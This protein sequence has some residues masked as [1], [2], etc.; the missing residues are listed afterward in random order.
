MNGNLDIYIEGERLDLFEDEN[1]VIN[2]SVQNINDISKV[3]TDY[4]QSFTLPASP[5][6]NRI[7]KH[8]YN[9]DIIN[10]FDSRTK[11][12]TV[13][14]IGKLPFKVG[15][16][17]LESVSIKNNRPENYKV[18]FVGNLVS[19]SELIGDDMLTNLDFSEYD[20]NYNSANVRTGLTTGFLGSGNYVFPL[21]STDKQWYYNSDAGDFTNTDELS[22]IAYNG[23]S[24]P[25]GVH[26][27]SLRPALKVSKIIEKIEARYG[28][29]FSDDFFGTSVFDNLFLWLER[30]DVIDSLS[31]D[32]VVVD[33]DN[34]G[35]YQPAIGSYNNSTGTYSTTE[36]GSD[37]LRA[38]DVRVGSTDGK[39]YT[40]QVVNNGDVMEE[41][42]IAGN[43]TEYFFAFDLPSG[44]PIGS[45][46]YLR[47]V[48]ST[49]KAFDFVYWRIKEF[50]EDTVLYVQKFDFSYGEVSA[51]TDI[52]LPELKVIDFLTSIIKMY[53]LT[54]L[55][56]STT[57]FSIKQLDDWYSEGNT[58]DVSGYVDRSEHQ[59]NR[60]E[61]YR[62]I[63]F[64]FEEPTT[65]LADQFKSQTGTAYGDL[66]AELTDGNGK[67]LEGDTYEISVDFE[68][69]VYER[70]TDQQTE[71]FTN[72]VYGL[73][74]DKDLQQNTPSSHL[75]YVKNVNVS[76]NS[77]SFIDDTEDNI[78]LDGN[79]Y[80]PSH[81]SSDGLNSTVFG[82]E[83]DE[84]T[85]NTNENSLYSNFYK[86]YITDTFS[87]KRRVYKYSG[88]FPTKLISDLQLNDKLVIDGTRYLI[89]EMQTN[90]STNEVELELLNDIYTVT[91]EVPP[92]TTKIVT[93]AYDSSSQSNACKAYGLGNT[94]PFYIQQTATFSNA[95]E[96]YSNANEAPA[97]TGWYSNGSIA[98]YWNGTS[99]T[100]TS[101]C[102][103]GGGGGTVEP[104]D[105]FNISGTGAVNNSSACELIASSTKY[106]DGL[107]N[108]PTLADIIYNDSSKTSVFNGGNLHY[109]IDGDLT[110]RI[111][112]GGVV[113]DVY[114]CTA[115]ANQ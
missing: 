74:L 21:I 23:N 94:A 8:W 20:F 64:N 65:I 44:V 52:F 103:T 111:T 13:I 4:S 18:V 67:P 93:L 33:Y 55:P 86:D 45:N 106:W 25:H 39:P 51:G 24:E 37:N 88:I 105:S 57:D 1:I 84:H 12:R 26:W 97:S 16:M 49:S 66:G 50:S 40:I 19:L 76:S 109:K 56:N 68:Q 28:F 70:L 78:E 73:T 113:N 5:K 107:Q 3:F 11:K 32:N 114:D 10:G 35:W 91:Y 60:P 27:Q 38:I 99:F 2:S 69:M 62:E 77:I 83:I 9:A 100:L 47:F 80:M 112:T 41:R 53:N 36:S 71:S 34:V 81:F 102:K 96:L 31:T 98:R 30:D 90:L 82:L 42:T 61:V 89:N 29:T 43:D 46:I 115:Q 75:F 7:F 15:K 79:V 58:Y 110:I 63:S 59:I 72:I 6:N 95:S 92:V 101:P 85:G 17:Q 14:E 54:I 104:A 22:N 87:S 108:H 48:T